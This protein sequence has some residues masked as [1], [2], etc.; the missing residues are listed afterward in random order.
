M[1]GPPK[2]ALAIRY[3]LRVSDW[4]ALMIAAAQ[5][6]DCDFLLTEDLQHDRS[7]DGL[8]VV[9]PFHAAPSLLGGRS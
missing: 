8:R 6:Q 5:Q 7:I 4:D 9:N 3:Q 2:C 1:P